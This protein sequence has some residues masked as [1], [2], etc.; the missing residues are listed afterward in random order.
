VSLVVG[1][2]C[3]Q[4]PRRAR[5]HRL[6]PTRIVLISDAHP[7][8]SVAGGLSA[9]LLVRTFG[10]PLTLGSTKSRVSARSCRPR[11]PS[12]GWIPY[13]HGLITLARTFARQ[14]AVAFPRILVGHYSPSAVARAIRSCRDGPGLLPARQSTTRAA[15][16]ASI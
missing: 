11:R 14:R 10:P 1:R 12:N 2:T 6:A 3:L 9:D 4:E 16:I 15:L 5:R 8:A 13:A 7:S